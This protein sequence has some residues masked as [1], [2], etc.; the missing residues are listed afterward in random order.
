MSFL[1]FVFSSLKKENNNEKII[2]NLLSISDNSLRQKEIG[3]I[4]TKLSK[5][6]FREQVEFVITVLD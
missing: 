3:R 5:S 2:E 6:D 4:S 1:S